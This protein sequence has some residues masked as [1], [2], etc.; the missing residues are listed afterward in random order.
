MS[1][2]QHSM[3]LVQEGNGVH[4]ICEISAKLQG[5]NS[6]LREN[7]ECIEVIAGVQKKNQKKKKKKNTARP[8]PTDDNLV[9]DV[10][11]ISLLLPAVVT[12]V[13]NA[14]GR[15]TKEA[16]KAVQVA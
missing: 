6:Q 13:T 12:A 9:F 1:E 4:R 10:N 2:F 15:S 14:I 3:K 7:H 8:F 11:D 16:E 5:E